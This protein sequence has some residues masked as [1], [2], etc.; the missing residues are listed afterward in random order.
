MQASN[1][2]LLSKAAA[3]A[4]EEA[5]VY[6][7]DVGKAHGEAVDGTLVTKKESCCWNCNTPGQALEMMKCKGCNKVRFFKKTF[8]QI[9]LDLPG[10]LQIEVQ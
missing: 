5:D 7:E 3:V 1:L 8:R 10:S 9:F 4:V 2:L 6:P